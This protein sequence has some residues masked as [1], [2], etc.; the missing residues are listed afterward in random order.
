M[1]DLAMQY[2]YFGLFLLSF[3][4]ATL[5]AAPSDVL[6]MG[7]PTAGFD[8]IIVILVATAGGYLGNLVNYAVGRYGAKFFLSR[9]VGDGQSDEKGWRQRAERLY[10]RYGVWTLLFS[11]T[12]FIGDPLTTVAGGFGVSLLTFSVLVII[13]KLVKFALLLG[14]TDAALVL[15]Q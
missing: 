2:G 8:P 4:A 6:A 5:I 15:F 13:G 14:V 12:P 9:W 3:L 10:E 7:M 11:G 1:I